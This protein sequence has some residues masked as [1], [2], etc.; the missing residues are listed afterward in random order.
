VS[1]EEATISEQWIERLAHHLKVEEYSLPT[2][3]KRLAIARQFLRYLEEQGVDVVAAAAEHEKAFLI[4]RLEAYRKRHGREPNDLSGWRWGQTSG[5]HMVVRLAQG[6]W[7]PVTIPASPEDAFRLN[8]C[9]AYARWLSDTRG[10]AATTIPNRRVE[11]RRFLESLGDRGGDQAHLA[12]ITVADLD[13]Y[14]ADRAPQLRRVTRQRLVVC[15]RGF[16]RYL[17][18]EGLTQQDLSGTLISPRR[19]AFETI[20]PAL[21]AEHVDAVLKAAEK[22]RTPKGLRDH[23]IL[24]LLATY[25]LRAGEVTALR[26][27]DIDWRGDRLR[28]RHSKT[29]CESFLPLLAPVGEAIVAYLRDGRPETKGRE[30]F[31]RVRAPFQSLRAGSSLYHMVEHR[32]Q[33]AEIK[34][35]RKHGPHAF[36]HARAV[37]LLNAGVAMKSIGDL[38]GHRSPESTA[39]YLKLA[40]SEL[41]AVGLEIPVGVSR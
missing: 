28:I 29:G 17:H 39:V 16:L 3:E 26:L 12:Q 24:L 37:G 31:L 8:L 7:P 35:E 19:Y 6:Q 21:R 27:D 15:M 40:T 18:I 14:L 34:L 13:H 2:T 41:R 20:P 9:D 36:R 32:L 22:D 30:V 25:G 11:A 33:K 38:L 5:I 10:L 1:V 23:A 4:H